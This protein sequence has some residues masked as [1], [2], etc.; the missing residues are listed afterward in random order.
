MRVV[1]VFIISTFRDFASER[2]LLVRK[3]FPEL[4]RRCRERQVE[5]V[6]VDLRWGITEAEA[7]QGKVLPI[8]VAEIKRSRPYIIGLLGER[9]GW[10]PQAQ[11]YDSSVA[12]EQSWLAEHTGGRSVTELEVL[13]GV[14]NNPDM[15]GQA[16]FY[17]RS[18]AYAQEGADDC[19]AES[20]EHREKLTQLKS[21]IRQSDFPVVEDY[22]NPEALAHRVEEDLWKLIDAVYPLDELPD[23]LALERRRHECY[24]QSRLG[25][26]LG[27]ESYLASLDTFIRENR[28]TVLIQGDSGSGKS[29]L[30][31]NWLQQ[32]RQAQ[33][34]AQ[35]FVHHLGS[36]NDAAEPAKLVRRW[37]KEFALILGEEAILPGE[38]DELYA[39]LPQWLAKAS[40]HAQQHGTRWV[41]V[42]D[43]LDKLREGRELRWLPRFVPSDVHL[44]VSCLTGD[45]LTAAQRRLTWEQVV[46]VQPL[47]N[48][49]RQHLIQMFLRKYRKSLTP[50]Q[51]QSM[52]S[53]PRTGNPLFLRTLLEELRVSGVH[54]G[55]EERIRVLLAAPTYKRVGA[56]LDVDDVF[57]HVLE[58]VEADTVAQ[59]VRAT[60]V[61]IWASR[62]G[63]TQDELLRI[64]NVT[65]AQ[66]AAVQL[67]LNEMLLESG[68][69]WTFSHHY[70]RKAV[71][72]RYA[73]VGKA[74]LQ[75]HRTLAESFAHLPVD[76]RV[77]EELPWQWER[78]DEKERLKECLTDCAMFLPLLERDTYELLAYWVR[79]GADVNAEYE[80]AW[81]RWGLK[82]QVELTASSLAR[83]LKTAGY[84]TD[85]VFALEKEVV[86]LRRENL[87]EYHPDTLEAMTNLSSSF[88]LI[89]DLKE[90]IRI[91]EEVVRLSRE[92]L[93]EYH[94][95]TVMFIPLLA[96]YYST[97]GRIEEAIEMIEEPLRLGREKLGHDH[98]R[99]L[100]M[101]LNLS[102][103]YS[104]SRRLEFAEEHFRLHNEKLG[105]DHPVTLTACT[106]RAEILV[107]LGRIE[108]AIAI[109]ENVLRLSRVTLGDDHCDTLRAMKSLA[110]AY[111]EADDDTDNYEIKEKA[112]T[113]SGEVL[114]LVSKKL[115]EEHPDTLT[116]M[117]NYADARHSYKS[118]IEFSYSAMKTHEEVL[119]LRR[120]KLGHDHPDTLEVMH[121]LSIYC[122]YILKAATS[123]YRLDEAIGILESVLHL[124]REKLGEDHSDTLEAMKSLAQAYSEADDDTDDYEIKEKAMT[125]S[126]EVLDLVSKKL[127]EEH[128]DTLTAMLNYADATD[129]YRSDM[130]FAYSAMKTHEEVLYL[131]RKKLGHDHPDTLEVMHSLSIYCRYILE[132]TTSSYL[133]DEAIG[134][135]ESVLHLSREKLGED[136]S[137]TLEAMTTLA[138]SYQKAGRLENAMVMG[139]E[140]VRLSRG[141]VGEGHPNTLG[142]M[143]T[144]AMAYGEA[145]R[146]DETLRLLEEVLRLN[147][148]NLGADHPETV[149]VKRSLDFLQKSIL[150]GLTSLSDKKVASRVVS[151]CRI[152]YQSPLS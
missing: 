39:I 123:S 125:M 74:R 117:L 89:S 113:L 148:E 94:P 93:E 77:L 81:Q 91:Q 35:M 18:T 101:M 31:A 120:K 132:A 82:E 10:V 111:S 12:Q 48:S 3:I 137:D 95:V 97:V 64:A 119:Y 143:K 84:Y 135:M 62:A 146:L 54:E 50:E 1:H 68:G 129:S 138:I 49:D 25:L 15:A 38:P 136:H 61:A 112:M 76:A 53:H 114:D 43:A 19:A 107:D 105:V 130:E 73:L 92:N 116:A 83:F 41:I 2:D 52:L 79:L 13:H 104:D 56:R 14:L 42:L 40:A 32:F 59:H 109:L 106:H 103:L 34:Y 9:Y 66:W 147:R 8:C 80:A 110:K 20:P 108:E 151:L 152:S 139:E 102:F 78:A 85:L 87:G 98:P 30:L 128:P 115:G 60:M 21:R 65:P 44:V 88:Y 45:V 69:R 96:F 134:I 16:L 51:E 142:A 118:E 70:M 126:G 141:K 57:E 72:D 7:Q 63:L 26:Y 150:S 149:G 75:A 90:A 145:G 11:Q 28:R 29:A 122:R 46:E 33:P 86:R 124:S 47:E 23:E 22:P 36:T 5:L 140:V 55:L 6:D 144:L 131:R 100:F 71:Q 4:R 24:S 37:I 99:I 127:G 17:F 121:S 133:L 67:Q 58:R 27:G